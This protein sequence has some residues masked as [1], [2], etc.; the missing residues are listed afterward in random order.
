MMKKTSNVVIA[1]VTAMG[2][3]LATAAMADESARPD[4]DDTQRMISHVSKKNAQDDDAAGDTVPGSD[5]R[6]ISHVSK[7]N[8]QDDGAAGDTVPGSDTR[9]ISHVSKVNAQDDGA[10]AEPAPAKAASGCE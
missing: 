5:T 7:V 9:M 10:S 6:M 2:L 8:A 1:T 4:C 3:C